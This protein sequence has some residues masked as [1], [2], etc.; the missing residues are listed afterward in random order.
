MI[1]ASC[2]VI[3]TI[4]LIMA[5]TYIFTKE[6][7]GTEYKVMITYNALSIIGFIAWFVVHM[8]MLKMYIMHGK[9]L[10]NDRTKLIQAK[11]IEVMKNQESQKLIKEE[12]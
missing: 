2:D 3:S 1:A 12:Q 4:P 5:K 8:L 7:D 6:F 11:L 10:E 9:P